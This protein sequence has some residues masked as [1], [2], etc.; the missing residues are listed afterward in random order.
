MSEPSRAAVASSGNVQGAIVVRRARSEDAAA[1]VRMRTALWPES[2]GDHPPEV[3]AYFAERPERWTCLVAEDATGVL[4]GFA[5]VALRDWAEG[6][7]TSPVGYLEGIWVEPDRRGAG[8]GRALVEGAV[9]WSRAR[10]CTEMGSD[11]NVDNEAS[12]AF[13]IAVGFRESERIVCYA[14]SLEAGR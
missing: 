3:E 1:W 8:V 13:H 9:G 10:G 6:C 14:K 4:A 12:G 11:R 2:P 5:E 7:S